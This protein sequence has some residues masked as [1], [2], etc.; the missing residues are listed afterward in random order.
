GGDET[1]VCG[2]GADHAAVGIAITRIQHRIGL[3]GIRIDGMTRFMIG[4]GSTGT[5]RGG[6]GF[7]AR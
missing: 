7:D 4:G 5:V 1:W 2:A 6:L 3:Q